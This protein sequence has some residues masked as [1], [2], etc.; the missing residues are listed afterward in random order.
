M[1]WTKTMPREVTMTFSI[2]TIRFQFSRQNVARTAATRLETAML[3]SLGA[4]G[5]IKLRVLPAT[6]SSML[7][8][9]QRD[10]DD[11]AKARSVN[12]NLGTINWVNLPKFHFLFSLS[13]TLLCFLLAPQ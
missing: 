11:S 7:K 8:I 10:T 3:F 13:V 1:K 12:G 5:S 2:I 6:I 9:K 4:S